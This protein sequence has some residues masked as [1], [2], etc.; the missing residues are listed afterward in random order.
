MTNWYITTNVNVAKW[1]SNVS[2]SCTF[3]EQEKET[4]IHLFWKCPCEQR[5]WTALNKWLNH[6][7]NIQANF[8]CAM[9]IFNG[10][11][12]AF[13][14]MTNT[15]ILI[16]KHYIYKQKRN[17]EK[18]VFIEL[19]KEISKYKTTEI[20]AARLKGTVKKIKNKWSIYDTV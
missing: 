18:P 14:D 6:Y 9:V 17:V 7:C 11:K 13:A 5:I 15:I 10:Y 20:R 3:C 12:D 2:E 1:D 19:V 16:T 4:L 8:E